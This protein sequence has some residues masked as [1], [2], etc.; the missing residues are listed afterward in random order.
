MPGF[1]RLKK[2][3][4]FLKAARGRRWNSD[5][6]LL[7]IKARVPADTAP[8]RF[9]FTITK[10]VGI[11]TVRN[12]IRRRLREAVRL[13]APQSARAGH[14]Y[15]LIGRRSAVK[16]PFANLVADLTKALDRGE[17]SSGKQP[18]E[19]AGHA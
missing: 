10:K 11:A 15:V 14:D 5:H 4:D 16:A 12:R 2:R 8:P 13:A 18:R 17:S 6:F 7:Q 9:G 1:E 19:K 3:R